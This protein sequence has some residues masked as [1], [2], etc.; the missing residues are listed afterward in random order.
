MTL[1]ATMKTDY[2]ALTS[3]RSTYQC[4]TTP[5]WIFVFS[6]YEVWNIIYT[7]PDDKASD[8][9]NF[10]QLFYQTAWPI[11]KNG[12]LADKC[13]NNIA[14]YEAILLGLP[15]LRAIRIQRCTLRTYS[16][17]VIGQIKK[18]CIANDSALERYLTLVRRMEN[19]FKGFTMEYIEQTKNIKT[20][21]LA[22]AAAC[23]TPLPADVFL[24][25][26]TDGSVKTIKMEPKMINLI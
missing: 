12:I 6:K 23:N 4:L 3:V 26:I 21:E 14:E 2:K 24:Q 20:D 13:A 17:V 22:K 10:T 9:D 25:V 5:L 19:H 18:E 7:V 15:K 11:I 16:N 8:P 1:L